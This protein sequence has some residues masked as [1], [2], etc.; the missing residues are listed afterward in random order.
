MGRGDARQRQGVWQ[1]SRA[2]MPEMR[3]NGYGKIVNIA[4][5]TPES[6]FIT[7]QV[8]AVDGGAV[9]N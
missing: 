2:V 5:T 7:G 1:A 8:I 6:D 4:S 9:M 3:R